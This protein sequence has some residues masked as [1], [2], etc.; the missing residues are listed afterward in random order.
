MHEYPQKSSQVRWVTG[1]WL[2]ERLQD[3]SFTL[4][5]SQPDVHDYIVRHIPGAVYMNEKLLRIV[6]GDLP[7]GYIPPEVMK[8]FMARV[9]IRADKPVVVYTDTGAFSKAGDGLEQT[10]M[11]YSLAR[12]GHPQVY[13]LD[14]G[15]PRWLDQHYPTT[16]KVPLP[17]Q[18]DFQPEL[19][20]SLYLSYEQFKAVKDDDDVVV[21]DVRP[22]ELY[23]GKAM[24]EKPGHIP[25]AYNLPWTNL[26][27]KHNSRQLAAD[28]HLEEIL[29]R[30][31]LSRDKTLVFYCGTGREA[32]AAFCVFRWYLAFPKV[33]L[34]EGSFTQWC[35]YPEN[36][37][38]TGPHPR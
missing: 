2:S 20:T 21:I 31:N 19:D 7:T 27:V 9:G 24:W 6:E 15:L 13:I 28:D 26:V 25:G 10:M 38:V 18:S 29:T 23:Q 14:G 3:R 37:T 35:L 1:Q 36:A 32:T 34:F 5:D 11:A 33:R 12:F 4:I 17:E 30:M 16:K 22:N 8:V